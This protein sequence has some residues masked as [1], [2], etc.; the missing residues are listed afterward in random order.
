MR[1]RV[2]NG[3]CDGPNS[4]WCGATAVTLIPTRAGN[5]A[6]E[7]L[8]VSGEFVSPTLAALEAAQRA[9]LALG[10]GRVFADTWALEQFST[11][12]VCLAARRERLEAVNRA[13]RDLPAIRSALASNGCAPSRIRKN[14]RLART[15]LALNAGLPLVQCAT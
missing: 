8:R 7:Q 2:W 10:R 9:A 4:R 13:Q 14:P 11:C 5:G 15:L 6:M 3:R 1:R 12:P